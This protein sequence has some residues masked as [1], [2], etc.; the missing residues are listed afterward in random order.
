MGVGN[1]KCKA[2][3]V[4]SAHREPPNFIIG[5]DFLGTHNCDLSLHY[6]LFMI[7][8]QQVKCTPEYVKTTRIK[9]KLASRVE[10]LPKT[11]V[12]VS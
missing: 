11:K 9:L 12:M 7:G 2:A 5:A 3:V 8:E 6:K 4:V 10:L 1:G